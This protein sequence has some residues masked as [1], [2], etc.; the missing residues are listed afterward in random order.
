[1]ESPEFSRFAGRVSAVF[2]RRRPE[3]ESANE[4]CAAL[5]PF[6]EVSGVAV[7]A[8]GLGGSTAGERAS[9]I[10]IEQL[11]RA[12][13]QTQQEGGLLRSAIISGIENANRAVRELG[14][15][16]MTTLAAVEIDQQAV[17]TYHIG[18][19]EILL[20]GGRGKLKF[21]TIS[22]SPV[23]YGVEAGL[24]DA[25]EAMH[26]E[27]RHLVSNVVGDA[28]MRIEI[29]PS[30]PLAARDTVIL[31]SDGLIDNLHAAEIARLIS[32]GPFRKAVAG[33]IEIA[34]QRML[35]PTDDQPSKIDD[36]TV[37]ALRG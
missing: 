27:D 32:K 4:D 22:H 24:L 3:G 10:A 13:A 18:D 20:V 33:I 2:S 16:A 21:Q 23:A 26:H 28:E 15:G 12:V 31:C 17:R 9:A 37:V 1:M 6:D 5:I 36:L 7:V 30:T 8:D 35:H 25:A 19:S 34:Y 29:G 11:Q 14:L